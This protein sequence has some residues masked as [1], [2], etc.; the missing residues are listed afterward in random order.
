[1]EGPALAPTEARRGW[2]GCPSSALLSGPPSLGTTLLAPLAHP[3]P[4]HGPPHL[5]QPW[6]TH[7]A[8][9]GGRSCPVTHQMKVP[10]RYTS[11]PTTHS[12]SGRAGRRTEAFRVHVLASVCNSW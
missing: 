5:Q 1:M 6:G 7:T 3:A 4:L 10:S 8:L 12:Y 2:H 11:S 9:P